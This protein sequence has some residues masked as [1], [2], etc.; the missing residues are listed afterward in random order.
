M[1]TAGPWRGLRVAVLHGGLKE[2]EKQRI[3]GQFAGGA[4]HAVV[5]TTVVEVGVD[6]P[7]ATIMIVEQAERFGLAQL[8][9]LRGRI[10]RGQR[11]GLC[12]LIARGGG[13]T[14]WQRLSVLTR[15]TDGFRIAEQDLRF[16]GP[17]ELFG[18]RQH[19]LPELRVADL[20]ADE[21]L[22]VAARNDAIAIVD[23]DPMLEKP[24]HA[25]LRATLLARYR[26][27]LELLDAG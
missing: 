4:L 24:E 26:G 9:Q 10:G 1:L 22:L 17:G 2:A 18:T 21:K 11:D 8:H 3:L 16:R 7:E 23:A 13:K 20:I 6:V 25:A 5:S 14:A 19:G 15:T 27:K 12:V